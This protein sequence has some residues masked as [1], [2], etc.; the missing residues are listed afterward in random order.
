MK[1]A[2]IC[3]HN[4]VMDRQTFNVKDNLSAG[5]F[6]S[7]NKPLAVG[8]FSLDSKRNYRDDLRQLKYIHMPNYFNVHFKLDHGRKNAIKKDE[9]LDEKLDH[10]LK[11][12]IQ[13]SKV[14]NWQSPHFVCFR[15]LLTMLLCTP[16]EQQEGWIILASKHGGTIFLC[17]KET[18]EKHQQ[19]ELMTDR[20]RQFMS[21][22]YKFEQYMTSDKPGREPDS[23][24]PVN[25]REELCVMFRTKLN[26]HR[27]LFGA[28][29]DGVNSKTAINSCA[30]LA[31]AEFIELK[32]S[33]QIETRRQ[34]DNFRRFKLIKWWGQSFLVGIKE[35]ICGFRDD[36]GIVH[37]LEPFEVSKLPKMAVK[38][39]LFLEFLESQ[40]LHEL[41]RSLP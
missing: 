11:W 34:D 31:Q 6:P 10:I 29:M 4:S 2:L 26:S 38:S 8:Y 1:C 13:N 40:C 14:G 18:E 33:R 5:T 9:H 32:T 17:A 3:I 22:G 12:L 27:L 19:R 35:V 7:Y 30:E 16:F 28:E 21:W 25:E 39:I 36:R 15:G 20:Q 41:L 37:R 24:Q 23:S